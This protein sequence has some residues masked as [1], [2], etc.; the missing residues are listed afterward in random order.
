MLKGLINLPFKVLG[1]V[2]RAVQERQDSVTQAKYGR[3]DERDD[4]EK[5]ANIPEFD[6]PADYATTSFPASTAAVRGWLS[7]QDPPTVLVDVRPSG[8]RRTGR[9]RD[10]D[11]IP[12]AAIPLRLSE[13]PPEGTRIVLYCDD[14]GFSREATRFIRFRG[15][16]DV[17]YLEGGLQAWKAAGAPVVAL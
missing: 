11:H 2:S 1:R 3:G 17:W 5:D 9:V 7:L 14:G 8:V 10:T 16:D 15:I 13:L 6:T 4:W 12:F